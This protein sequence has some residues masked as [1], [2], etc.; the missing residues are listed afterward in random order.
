MKN[1]PPVTGI[2]PSAA[3]TA[4][5]KGMAWLVVL[6]LIGMIG[7][8]GWWWWQQQEAARRTA[9]VGAATAAAGGGPGAAAGARPVGAGGAGRSG[10]AATPVVA[11]AAVAGD[12]PI[13]LDAL[14]TVTAH[15]TATVKARV[16]G[17]LERVHFREGDMVEAG[18]LLAEIDARQLKV[19]LDQA[20]G[21]LARDRAQLENAR[22]DLRRY[23]T[24]FKQ[25]SIARQQVDT[26]AA[27]VRQLEGA[28]RVDQSTVDNA[29]LQ[30]SFAR[31]TAPISGRAGLR[32][33]DPGNM[34]TGSETNGLV[35]IT[36][37]QPISALFTLPQDE[38]PAIRRR[39]ASGA[40]LTVTAWDRSQQH[41]LATGVL[42]SI[43]NQIDATTGTIR[44][45]ARFDNKDGELFP[46]Q[47]VNIRLE[48]DTLKHA[49]TIPSAA[50]QRGSQGLFVYVVKA[51]N[52]VTTRPIELGPVHG[53]QV[54]VSKGLSAG[55]RVVIDGI[56]RLRD[57]ASV[58]MIERP[59]FSA[60]PPPP[61]PR[62]RPG[63]AA[64]GG[65][66]GARPGAAASAAPGAAPGGP[67]GGGAGGAPR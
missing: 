51:D 4:T 49:I 20:E 27:L 29:R 63:G 13:V 50:I 67:A 25:D 59:D 26:Q 48:R 3:P 62:R 52:T 46:N 16:P 1:D 11:V 43:D 28:V 56:D 2:P 14:G 17:L 34:V 36:Q 42:V 22:V 57:G 5:G 64:G 44:L 19:Q 33:V 41:R 60:P 15:Q 7:G 39:I 30:L 38:L 58:E 35:I 61:Q 45:R 24:L 8:G 23:E 37:V 47:F 21:Q 31:V 65:P 9:Q 54:A 12:V 66:P 55:E 18:Q 6:L 10:P 32:Q 40:E 53:Q